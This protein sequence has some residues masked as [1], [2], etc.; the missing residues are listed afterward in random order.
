MGIVGALVGLWL[1]SVGSHCR[2]PG[3]VDRWSWGC[4]EGMS[5]IRGEF[6][7]IVMAGMQQMNEIAV[8]FDRFKERCLG[9]IPGVIQQGVNNRCL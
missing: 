7:G 8:S 1:V 6:T 3:G 2:W 5:M 9:D 4:S